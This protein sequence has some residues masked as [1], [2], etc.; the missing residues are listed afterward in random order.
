MMGDAVDRLGAILLDG[1]VAATALLGLAALAMV[2][3]GQPARRLTLG[4]AAIIGALALIP[5]AVFAPVP[6]VF[7][8]PSLA[9][10]MPPEAAPAIASPWPRPVQ[11][12]RRGALALAAIGTV[13]GLAALGLGGIA[14]RR[15]MR[16]TIEPAPETRALYDNLTSEAQVWVRPRLRVSARVRSPVLVG[17]VRPTILIPPDLDEPGEEAP[18]RLGLLHELAH[19]ERRDPI[20]GL[21]SLL[22]GSLWFFVP[23]LWWIRRQMRVDQEFLADRC[24]SERFGTGAAY[25]ASLVGMASGVDASGV[26]TAKGGSPSGPIAGVSGLFQRVLMLIRCPFPIEARSPSW[27][28]ALCV[29]TLGCGAV[30]ASGLTLVD[31]PDGSGPNPYAPPPKCHDHGLLQVARLMI[32]ARPAGPGGTVPPYTL[33]QSLPERFEMVAQVWADPAHLPF[34]AIAGRR[35]GPLPDRPGSAPL[36]AGFHKVRLL[37]DG[38][39][40][41]LWVAGRVVPPGPNDTAPPAMLELQPA[42][43]E[44]GRYRDLTLTW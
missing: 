36:L 43:D 13:G 29:A 14:C 22:V 24:A 35:L 18:L 44:A 34:M 41:H 6:K 30:V 42:P 31:G 28:V 9:A 38:D 40:I 7:L 10:I 2:A 21:A 17:A 37:R 11:W 8:R 27:W 33:L 32:D 20:F 25:A 23:P 15:L 19:Y 1:A 39:G 26:G 3:C 12:W 4:R 16:R 5:L